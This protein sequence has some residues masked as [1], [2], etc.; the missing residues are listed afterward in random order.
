MTKHGFFWSFV[1]FQSFK[2]SVMLCTPAV[3]LFKWCGA[4]TGKDQY[5]LLSKNV[6][7]QFV[8]FVTK[9]QSFC[10]LVSRNKGLNVIFSMIVQ[11]EWYPK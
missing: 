6:F 7:F 11:G 4:A 10:R 2:C 8:G 9:M 1:Y 5:L 3:R